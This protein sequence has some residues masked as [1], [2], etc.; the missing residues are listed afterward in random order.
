[1]WVDGWPEPNEWNQ[2]LESGNKRLARPLIE[3]AAR[4]RFPDA[5]FLMP[6]IDRANA[7]QW[8]QFALAN[9][10]AK[11]RVNFVTLY[12]RWP[13]WS[14]HWLEEI[15]VFFANREEALY[16][17]EEAMAEMISDGSV[18]ARYCERAGGIWATVKTMEGID[19]CIYYWEKARSLHRQDDNDGAAKTAEAF[20]SNFKEEKRLAQTYGDAY[21]RLEHRIAN[22]VA[23][24]QGR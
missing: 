9:S 14:D 15:N 3:Q 10:D 17:L 4:Q 22:Q 11:L 1:M 16:Y 20:V 13:S 21:W 18:T 2:L 23:K 6:G 24:M 12:F 19:R 5:M 8:R 7:S